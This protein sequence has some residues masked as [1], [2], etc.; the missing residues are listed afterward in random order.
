MPPP[1]E[2]FLCGTTE[3][4]KQAWNTAWWGGFAKHILHPDNPLSGHDA[5]QVLNDAQI[6]GMCKDCL[7]NAVG[8]AWEVNPFD[9]L[10]MVCEGIGRVVKWI[11]GE[12][13]ESAYLQAQEVQTQMQMD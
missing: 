8:S 11:M 10:E 9:E 6:P 7:W 3:R 2:S 12:V 4:C 13:I 5:M 1:V